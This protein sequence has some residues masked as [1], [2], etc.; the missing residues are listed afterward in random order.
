[1]GPAKTDIRPHLTLCPA[2]HR[3]LPA[4]EDDVPHNPDSKHPEHGSDAP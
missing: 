4:A 1:M 3:S 2:T